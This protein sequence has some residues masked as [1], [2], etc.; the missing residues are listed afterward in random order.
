MKYFP[1]YSSF[2]RF[3]AMRQMSMSSRVRPSGAWYGTPWKPSITCG[4]E[5]PMPRMN[6]P[7][8][9]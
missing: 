1:W 4:P 9:T 6:R 7:S 3:Q 2:S 5:A 8:L